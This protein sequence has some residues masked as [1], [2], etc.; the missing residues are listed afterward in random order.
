MQWARDT[1]LCLLINELSVKGTSQYHRELPLLRLCKQR[2]LLVFSPRHRRP[3]PP[4]HA[5]SLFFLSDPVKDDS[6]ENGMPLAF[7]ISAFCRPLS[8]NESDRAIAVADS[9]ARSAPRN[10][11]GG[12]IHTRWCRV[13][14][15][16]RFFRASLSLFLS[17]PRD[18]NYSVPKRDASRVI[19]RGTSLELQSRS[20]TTVIPELNLSYFYA[21]NKITIDFVYRCNYLICDTILSQICIFILLIFLLLRYICIGRIRYSTTYKII[22][23]R[24]SF[25][26]RNRSTYLLSMQSLYYR[27]K[28]VSVTYSIKYKY[29]FNQKSNK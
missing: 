1:T 16:S 18:K 9:A 20:C 27:N 25:N 21:D 7:L 12:N 15:G 23:I 13:A 28:P 4:S 2:A 29:K 8:A 22:N 6:A 11:R 10:I 24:A 26:Y 19:T 14:P 5:E 3:R 17:L